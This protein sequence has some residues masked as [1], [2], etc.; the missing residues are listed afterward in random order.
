MIY[1]I[2]EQQGVFIPPEKHLLVLG[3]AS[4]LGSK[5]LCVRTQYVSF[6]ATTRIFI[7]QPRWSERAVVQDDGTWT[8]RIV[9]P[10]DFDV[11]KENFQAIDRCSD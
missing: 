3:R 10:L 5:A 4:N 9:V 1:A 8:A 2:K 7:P 11:R 6:N